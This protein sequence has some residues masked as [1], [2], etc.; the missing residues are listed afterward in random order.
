VGKPLDE[1]E[2]QGRVL[3]AAAAGSVAVR[4]SYICHPEGAPKLVAWSGDGGTYFGR[5]G[6]RLMFVKGTPSLWQIVQK[7]GC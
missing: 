4:N 7:S 5:I 1:A 6:Q 2:T 3:C